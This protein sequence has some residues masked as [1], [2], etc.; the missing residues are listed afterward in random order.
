M[1][2]LQTARGRIG[3]VDSGDGPA[4]LFV[5]GFPLDRS[6]WQHQVDA[7]AAT[8]RVIA[9]DLPGFGESD[10]PSETVTMELYA[11]T[12]AA[13]L[14]A[15]NIK[16]AVTFCGLSMGGYIAW[17]FWKRHRDR[18]NRM[19]LCDT[20]AASDTTQ[21]ARGRRMMAE[22]VVKRGVQEGVAGML[23]KLFAKE[24]MRQLQFDIEVV[25]KR[26]LQTDPV[27]FAAAQNAMAQRISAID[28]LPQIDIPVLVLTGTDDQITPVS[29]AKTWTKQIPQGRLVEIEEAGH[30]A[31]LENPDQVNDA[32]RQFMTRTS[33][34]SV[35]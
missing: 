32:I 28:M 9:L 11:D 1:T 5:H 17:Q 22:L 15:M 35:E 27:Q 29:E 21:I 3:Y 34:R 25:R 12:C 13:F 24:N 4:I 23:P 7:L 16:E 31:P 6:Q 18:L 20:R 10:P 14:D 8:F 2:Q 19:I 26:M 30:L 33:G